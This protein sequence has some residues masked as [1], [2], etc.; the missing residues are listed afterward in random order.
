M[1]SI[2]HGHSHDIDHLC[3]HAV[4]LKCYRFIVKIQSMWC[5]F[6][7]YEH[8]ID[9]SCLYLHDI[10]HLCI[11]SINL[12]PLYIINRCISSIYGASCSYY[13][14]YATYVLDKYCIR[15]IL[16]RVHKNLHIIIDQLMHIISKYIC[17]AS[18]LLVYDTWGSYYMYDN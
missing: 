12:Y 14:M 16:G 15:C 17:Y 11:L 2:Y 13:P 6:Y 9:W 18:L 7:I 3:M 8:V 5:M 4:L 10:K 1:I